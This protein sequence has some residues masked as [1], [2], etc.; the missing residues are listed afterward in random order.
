MD[1]PRSSTLIIPVPQIPRCGAHAASHRQYGA[2]RTR[3]T[4][5]DRRSHL[6]VR[7]HSC[8]TPGAQDS[9]T[10]GSQSRGPSR[11]VGQDY[12]ACARPEGDSFAAWHP[13]RKGIPSTS[14][15]R[16]SLFCLLYE[17]RLADQEHR[18]AATNKSDY[19]GRA[20]ESNAGTMLCVRASFEVRASST[21]GMPLEV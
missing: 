20:S 10:A 6:S 15:V 9:V 19:S 12:E 3:I 4:S 2:R 17:N 1:N 18:D 5:D 16:G 14:A 8:V 7:Q 21:I 13:Q 11:A